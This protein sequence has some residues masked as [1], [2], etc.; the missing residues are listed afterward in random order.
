MRGFVDAEDNEGAKI[1]VEWSISASDGA[2]LLKNKR[3]LSAFRGVGRAE[4]NVGATRFQGAGLLSGTAC[5]LAELVY[6][7]DGRLLRHGMLVTQPPCRIA[8]TLSV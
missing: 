1:G 8:K 7:H 4:R 2:K 6:I 5:A 3:S